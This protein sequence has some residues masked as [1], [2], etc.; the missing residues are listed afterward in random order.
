MRIIILLI[1]ILIAGPDASAQ[2]LMKIDSA[3]KANSEAIPLKMKGGITI[4]AIMKYQ[5]GPYQV[6]STK[7]GWGKSK[8]NI[9]KKTE[10]TESKQKASFIL[11]ANEKDTISTNL[12]INIKTISSWERGFSIHYFSPNKELITVSSTLGS[13]TNRSGTYRPNFQSNTFRLLPPTCIW[14]KVAHSK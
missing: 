10:T 6:I 7:A 5:F 4:G 13:F 12:S 8:S 11:T 14:V 3:L 2:K 1:F 9:S